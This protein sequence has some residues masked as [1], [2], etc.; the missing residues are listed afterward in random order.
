MNSKA[1]YNIKS[2]FF[3]FNNFLASSIKIH[4][5]SSTFNELF[6]SYS[7]SNFSLHFPIY[8]LVDGL[9]LFDN[10]TKYSD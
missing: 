8:N 4:F 3:V 6:S 5:K 9:P 2:L 7:F 1:S 10:P